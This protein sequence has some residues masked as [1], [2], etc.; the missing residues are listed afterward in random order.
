[1]ANIKA[2]QQLRA[3]S[4]LVY[5]TA[6]RQSWIKFCSTITSKTPKKKVWNI[7]KKIKG[8][9]ECPTA[10]HLQFSDTLITE[11]KAV[12]NLLAAT[13]E[14]KTLFPLTKQPHF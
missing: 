14:K 6:K 12:S 10:K 3:K 8:K 5:K 1:M 11:K 4:R 2:H 9:N 7:I 13:I